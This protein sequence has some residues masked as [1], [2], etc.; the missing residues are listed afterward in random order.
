M[1]KL[2]KIRKAYEKRINSLEFIKEYTIKPHIKSAKDIF[3]Q[4]RYLN[5]LNKEVFIVACLD[6][7]NKVTCHE[8]ISMGILD[9]SLIHPREVFKTA[10]LYSA[11]RI[12]LI[13][14]HPSGDP[15]PSSE[16]LE[17]TRKLIK[18]GDL[19]GIEVLDHIVIGKDN[20]WSYIEG[21][22]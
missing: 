3:E 7:K 8:I 17:I 12:V 16:D 1:K 13:H 15:S 11:A 14:N 10:I 18:S 6:T 20:F 21:Q 5:A 4:F 9:A 2:T 22:N 19:L